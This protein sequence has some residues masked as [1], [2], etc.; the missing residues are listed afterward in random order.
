ADA[1]GNPTAINDENDNFFS[2]KTFDNVTLTERFS[3]LVGLDA[4][5]NVNGQGLI[6]KFEIKKDRSATLAISNLQVTETYGTEYVIGSGYKFPK[7]K[8]PFKVKNKNL[9]N[10]LNLRFDLSIRENL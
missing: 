9:E 3:P 2:A 6:T 7:V 4:T 8:L 1:S 10:P 5:W